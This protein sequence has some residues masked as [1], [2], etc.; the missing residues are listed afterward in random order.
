MKTN[1]K[2]QEHFRVLPRNPRNP[3]NPRFRQK[4]RFQDMPR[5]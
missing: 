3:R 4:P 5:Y 1:L 2:K